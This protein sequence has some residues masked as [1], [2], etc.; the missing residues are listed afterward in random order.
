LSRR[1]G[2]ENYIRVLLMAVVF[3]K[4]F[5]SLFQWLYFVKQ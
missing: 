4:I 5:G 1:I 3:G 2:L